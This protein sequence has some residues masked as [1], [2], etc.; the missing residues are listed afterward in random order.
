MGSVFLQFLFLL[1]CS[2]RY[3]Y[4]SM[5]AKIN[6]YNHSPNGRID[7]YQP[8]KRKEQHATV[9]VDQERRFKAAYSVNY[10]QACLL[11]QA[12]RMNGRRPLSPQCICMFI[13]SIFKGFFILIPFFYSTACQFCF[14]SLGIKSRGRKSG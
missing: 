7:T 11:L 3:P 1:H 5:K 4:T 6:L 14:T 10:N 8:Y 2:P 13:S 9:A 12:I